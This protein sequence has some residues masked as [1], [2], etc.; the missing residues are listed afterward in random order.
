[1]PT[2]VDA[3]LLPIPSKNLSAYQKMAR[4]AA[5]VWKRHGALTY[6]EAVL[7]DAG[8]SFCATFPQVVKPKKG[9]TIVVAFV[10]YKSRAHRDR[11]NK[12]VMEDPELL[13]SCGDPTKMPFDVARMACSGFSTIA[14]S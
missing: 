14:E 4:T 5:R 7:E 10:T 2:Y 9:E 6:R 1:M 3:Y 13:E 8:G 11:V 12:R